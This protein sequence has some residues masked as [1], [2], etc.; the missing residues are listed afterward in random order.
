MLDWIVWNRTVYMYKNEFGI[1]NQQFS[2]CHKTKP[3][4]IKFFKKSKFTWFNLFFKFNE[5][6]DLTH[7]VSLSP[8][9]WARGTQ[10][11]DFLFC[12]ILSR[13]LNI[14]YIYIYI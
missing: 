5:F 10:S 3:N 6:Y 11:R 2:M 12:F 8:E 14:E 4:R 9:D 13:C 1:N 7:Q